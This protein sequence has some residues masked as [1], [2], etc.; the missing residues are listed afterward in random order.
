MSKKFYVLNTLIGASIIVPMITIS[1]SNTIKNKNEIKDNKSK[2]IALFKKVESSSVNDTVTVG[3]E[4]VVDGKKNTYWLSDRFED[5]PIGGKTQ[6]GQSQAKDGKG[7]WLLIDLGEKQKVG[8][9]QIFLDRDN[10]SEYEIYASDTKENIDKWENKVYSWKKSDND[11]EQL[12]L[13]GNFKQVKENVQ[14]V[15]FKALKWQKQQNTG[16]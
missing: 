15:K 5:A 14:F 1:Q 7:S 2:N 11:L 12:V 9:F 8:S 4:K 13:F 16:F 3:P 6:S 10:I